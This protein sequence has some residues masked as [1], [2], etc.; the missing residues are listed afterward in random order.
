MPYLLRVPVTARDIDELD[1]ASNVSY[2]RWVLDAALSH[3]SAVG[4]DVAAFRARGQVFV[5]HRHELDYLRPALAGDLLTVET[6]VIEM[7]T[8]SSVRETLIHR[9]GDDK[10]LFHG[11][12]SWAFIDLRSGRPARIPDDVRARFALDPPA[13]PA[14]RR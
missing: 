5:V 12:T 14:R 11:R 9:E 7:R 4:L 10:L 6:R 3:S 1:H 2:V 8:A 13:A